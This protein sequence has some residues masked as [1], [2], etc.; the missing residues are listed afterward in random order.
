MLKVFDISCEKK[1]LLFGTPNIYN[2][3]LDLQQSELCN[4]INDLYAKRKI[5]YRPGLENVYEMES[6]LFSELSAESYPLKD[7]LVSAEKQFNCEFLSRSWL[8]YWEILDQFLI[9]RITKLINEKKLKKLLADKRNEGLNVL[10]PDHPILSFH[11]HDNNLT[12][13][14]V[15]N[16]FI[17]LLSVTTGSNFDWMW[18]ANYIDASQKVQKLALIHRQNWSQCGD[19]TNL[20]NSGNI[21]THKNKITL[22]SMKK[23]N[24]YFFDNPELVSLNETI[25]TVQ[26]IIAGIS[27]LADDGLMIIKLPL[28]FNSSLLS[29]VHIVTNCFE[30][31]YIVYPFADDQQYLVADGFIHLKAKQ[32]KFLLEYA[33]ICSDLTDL[34]TIPFVAN[35]Q[36]NNFVETV[37]R[38]NSDI[39]DIKANLHTNLLDTYEEISASKSREYFDNMVEDLIKSRFAPAGDKWLENYGLIPLNMKLFG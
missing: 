18:N 20:N 9:E 3:G 34:D 26:G 30:K 36:F 14:S 7:L 16:H 17:K 38:I 6:K 28:I 15:M 11:M 19:G 2:V 10:I 39:V 21:R 35:D 13:L 22:G 31:T 23:L 25:R 37:M 4:K 29:M 1:S 32:Y 27:L 12:T 33:D 24:I 5:K 8:C